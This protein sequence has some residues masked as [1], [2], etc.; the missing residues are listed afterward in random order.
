MKT[1]DFIKQIEALDSRFTVVEN[2]N[3][4][5]L[6]NIFFEGQNYDLPVLPTEEIKESPDPRYFYTFPNGY[7]APYNDMTTVM[8]KLKEFLADLDNKRKIHEEEA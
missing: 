7:S 8:I 3:R 2:P 1:K 5:G 4:A 6:S